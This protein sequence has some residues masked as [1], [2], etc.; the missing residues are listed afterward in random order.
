M[1]PVLGKYETTIDTLL[2]VAG[3][4]KNINVK[5]MKINSCSMRNI[6]YAL[7]NKGPDAQHQDV[8]VD[9]IKVSVE[10]YDEIK[11]RRNYV[12]KLKILTS[13]N[14]NMQLVE[15]QL[16][17]INFENLKDKRYDGNEVI[18]EN[19]KI[20]MRPFGELYKYEISDC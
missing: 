4:D 17:N 19:V 15:A 14:E 8:L 20:K 2:T 11:E 18:I 10:D 16:G 1:E 5:E 9:Y 7:K 13:V 6:E 12:C 3:T